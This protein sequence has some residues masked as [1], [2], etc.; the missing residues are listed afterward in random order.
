MIEQSKITTEMR[1]N[2]SH[3]IYLLCS[4]FLFQ[5]LYL[6]FSLF[7]RERETEIE[8]LIGKVVVCFRALMS[9]YQLRYMLWIADC[10]FIYLK[11]V[12]N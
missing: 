5:T 6:F 4:P 1:K 3:S 9:L 7:K 12:Q 2:K 8:L 10:I 11:R